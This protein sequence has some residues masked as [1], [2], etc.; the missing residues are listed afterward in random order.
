MTVPYFSLGL[1]ANAKGTNTVVVEVEEDIAQGQIHLPGLPATITLAH[2]E[3]PID[4][5]VNCDQKVAREYYDAKRYNITQAHDPVPIEYPGTVTIKTNGPGAVK[6]YDGPF[7]TGEGLQ[8]TMIA[9]IQKILGVVPAWGP[10]EIV[11]EGAQALPQLEV[12]LGNIETGHKELSKDPANPTYTWRW[13]G[14]FSINKT[15]LEYNATEKAKDVPLK[16]VFHQSVGRAVN[17]EATLKIELGGLCSC[18]YWRELTGTKDT[19][20]FPET[21]LRFS[22]PSRARLERVIAFDPPAKGGENYRWKL[23]WK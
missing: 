16:N 9:G 6:K 10:V 19:M 23:D 4:W 7:L 1:A 12:T 18:D 2:W 11:K 21:E 17:S 15:P 13:S 14:R 20:R 22:T 3:M 5:E 8:P